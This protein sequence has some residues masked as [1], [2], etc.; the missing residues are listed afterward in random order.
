M[1]KYKNDQ[2][3]IMKEVDPIFKAKIDMYKKFNGQNKK[4]EE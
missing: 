2:I 1:E 4:G 3:N